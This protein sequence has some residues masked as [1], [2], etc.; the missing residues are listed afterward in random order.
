MMLHFLILSNVLINTLYSVIECNKLLFASDD[1]CVRSMTDCI[2]I[3]SRSK[4]EY[5]YFVVQDVE[6]VYIPSFP[7][8]TNIHYYAVRVLDFFMSH[9][10]KLRPL[11]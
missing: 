3:R 9:C 11:C 5:E 7:S 2:G 6:F 4:I 10:H 8:I 1:H